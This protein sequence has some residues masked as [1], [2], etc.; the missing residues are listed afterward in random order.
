MNIL[1][2]FIKN[3]YNNYF[4]YL[5]SFKIIFYNNISSKKSSDKYRIIKYSLKSISKNEL[6]QIKLFDAYFRTH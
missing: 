3:S 1:N 6:N 2:S 4:M 5:K